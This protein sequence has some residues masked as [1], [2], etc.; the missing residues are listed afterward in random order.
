[1][2]MTEGRTSR[3]VTPVFISALGSRLNRNRQFV[4]PR[5]PL[6]FGPMT[7]LMA[8]SRSSTAPMNRMWCGIKPWF[9][10]RSCPQPYR[11]RRFHAASLLG[12]RF[13]TDAMKV[14]SYCNVAVGSH[15]FIT[16]RGCPRWRSDAISLSVIAHRKGQGLDLNVDHSFIAMR[17]E[18]PDPICLSA[19]VYKVSSPQS[20]SDSV[21]ACICIVFPV[22]SVKSYIPK[23][24]CLSLR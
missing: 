21:F 2:E 5:D 22:N 20:A 8:D 14:K 24:F 6:Y 18:V 17:Y 16:I 13:A 19:P 10:Y 9:I 15:A 23:P 11:N 3:C 1:M 4:T 7:P 12:L